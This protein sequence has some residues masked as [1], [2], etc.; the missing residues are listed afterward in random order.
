VEPCP[1]CGRQSAPDVRA[2][3]HCGTPL[4]FGEEPAP[5]PL[6]REL[7]LDRR[8]PERV[9]A[10]TA[11]SAPFDP[12]RSDWGLGVAADPAPEPG[13][14]SE[15]AGDLRPAPPA[16]RAAAWAIDGALVAIAGAAL[17][18]ALLASSGALRSAGSLQ[19]AVAGN[20][21]IVL[22]SVAFVAVAAFVYATVAHALA[23]ATLGKRIARI[24]VVDAG[25]RPPGIACSASRSAWA[26]ASIALAGAGMLPAVLGPSRR[27]LHDLLAGTRVVEVP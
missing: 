22:P 4:A 15:G 3:A 25:G 14:A 13:A 27:A 23:G 9:P 5:R 20:L 11:D 10:E 21:P 24:R 18:L 2:C 12:N 8:G 6:D 17:P 16:R 19:R 26:V 1:R 7:D